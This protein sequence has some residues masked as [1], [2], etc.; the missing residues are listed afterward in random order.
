MIPRR[1][2]ISRPLASRLPHRQLGETRGSLGGRPGGELPQAA[3]L[4]LPGGRPLD[5]LAGV[6]PYFE[7]REIPLWGGAALAAFGTLVFTGVVVGMLFA[8]RRASQLGIPDREIAN[9]IVCA[10]AAGFLGSHAMVL[11]SAGP[12][13]TGALDWLAFWNG[14]DSFGGFFGALVGLALYFRR[15]PWVRHADVL[16]QAL[17]MG[18]VF[19]R[20]GCSL[21][22]DHVG[23]RTDFF[24]ALQFP[25]GA[26]H[27]LGLYEFLFTLLVLV[28][29]VLWLNRRPRPAGTT[30]WVI[31][32]LYAPVR[33]L[34]DFLRHTDLPYPD[35][36]YAGLTFAQYAS[37]VSLG[38]AFYFWRRTRR[39]E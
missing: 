9:A 21:V 27:D 25:G 6:I 18:W 35:A 10:V 28:P 34:L 31:P 7:L 20:L 8:L 1:L 15:R 38:I 24:L 17:V 32:L 11:L 33:F 4:A 14:M 19:G 16:L 23:R 37:L 12:A 13:E 22:H 5:T 30:L 2:S 3:A 39:A 29:A 26:R 36:R